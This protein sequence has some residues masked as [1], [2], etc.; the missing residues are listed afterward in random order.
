VVRSNEVLKHRIVQYLFLDIASYLSGGDK[1]SGLVENLIKFP[2]AFSV[3]PS[4]IK[5]TQAFWL[6]DHE[7]FDE[8][9]TMLLDPIISNNDIELWQ[10]RAV[11][12]A[13]LVQDQAKLALKYARIRQPP[14]KDL[15]DIQMHVSLFKTLSLSNFSN[16]L[17]LCPVRF[18]V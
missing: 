10:H 7:D 2:S 3:T 14:Q 18:A 6:L 1:W 12:V 5:L 16:F 9:L 11:L 13:F 17:H 4:L 15:V 8:A